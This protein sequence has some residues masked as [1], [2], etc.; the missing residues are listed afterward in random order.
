[1]FDL[2]SLSVSDSLLIIGLFCCMILLIAIGLWVL[3]SRDDDRDDLLGY[4]FDYCYAE[5][6]VRPHED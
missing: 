4:S 1:M 5:D 2:F 3:R 6:E